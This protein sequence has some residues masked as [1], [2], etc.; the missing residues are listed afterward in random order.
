M[1]TKMM[2][3]KRGW[4][5]ALATAAT[6]TTGSVMAEPKVM[7]AIGNIS[8]NIAQVDGVERPFF[9]ELAENVGIETNVQ[10]NPMDVVGLSGSDALRMLRSGAFDLMSVQIGMVS[11]DDPFFEGL[12][13]NGVSPTLEDLREA[14]N[15][16]REVFDE[17]LQEKFNAKV[18]T[19]WPFGEMVT[20]CNAPLQ[21]MDDLRGKKV[22]VFTSSMAAVMDHFGAT[23]VSLQLNEVYPALQRGVV[24]CGVVA[25]ATA[26]SGKWPEVTTHV[27][28]M[29]LGGGVQGHFVSLNHWNQYDAEQQEKLVEEFKKLEQR[30]WDLA[31]NE[32]RSSLE[33]LTGNAECSTGEKLNMTLV[34]P[35]EADYAKLREAVN[36]RVLPAWAKNCNAVD[37][38]C[39]TI[40]NETVGQA[41][42]LQIQ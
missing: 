26:V 39:T 40:W 29:S 34:E 2:N 36:T 37:P 7:R 6:L 9:A 41:A 3:M 28:P 32:S 27:L 14:I 11:R 15:S 25:A 12:D 19:I 24:D 22:R 20:F 10:Y 21:S 13:L 38:Q 33:C 18:L 31:I 5:L 16:Y 4:M 35:T 17:R 42:D 1:K 23:P 30:M 8:V